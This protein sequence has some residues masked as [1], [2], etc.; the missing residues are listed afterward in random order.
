MIRVS[1]FMIVSI[2]IYFLLFIKFMVQ[3]EYL[4]GY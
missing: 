2:S 4:G 3:Y 1:N